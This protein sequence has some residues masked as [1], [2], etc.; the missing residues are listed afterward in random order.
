MLYNLFLH[1]NICPPLSIDFCLEITVHQ[2]LNTKQNTCINFS[3]LSP[4]ITNS[5]THYAE[6]K[7]DN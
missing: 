1:E 6:I 4:I 3:I 7:Q 5:N 2:L